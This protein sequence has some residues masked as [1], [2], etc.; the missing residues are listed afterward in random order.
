MPA[1]WR[2]G[3]PITAMMPTIATTTISSLKVKPR[4]RAQPPAAACRLWSVW[5][6]MTA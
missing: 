1:R 6:L 4:C 5:H 2:F 3:M